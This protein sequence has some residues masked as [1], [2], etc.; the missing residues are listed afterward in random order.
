VVIEEKTH[1]TIRIVENCHQFDSVSHITTYPGDTTLVTFLP[2][3][4]RQDDALC[5]FDEEACLTFV[6][7]ADGRVME[8]DL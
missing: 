5:F 6:Q 3:M 8:R 1:A 4:L 7:R 2:S